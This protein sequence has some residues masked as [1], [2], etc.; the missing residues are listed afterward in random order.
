[1]M[2]ISGDSVSAGAKHRE[3]LVVEIDPAI[4]DVQVDVAVP[5]VFETAAVGPAAQPLIRTSRQW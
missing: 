3:A 1:M 4:A 5:E 2:S